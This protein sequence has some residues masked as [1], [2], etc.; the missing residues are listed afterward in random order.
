[1]IKTDTEIHL[2]C[3]LIEKLVGELLLE[4]ADD[5][6][7]VSMVYNMFTPETLE[8]ELKYS[9]AILYGKFIILN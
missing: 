2:N 5:A 3:L 6:E 4:G 8:Q 9:K 1:M 7:L